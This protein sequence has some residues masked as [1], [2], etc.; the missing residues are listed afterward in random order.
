MWGR[1]TPTVIKHKMALVTTHNNVLHSNK[2]CITIHL[3]TSWTQGPLSPSSGGGMLV[4][5]FPALLWESAPAAAAPHALKTSV[6]LHWPQP[7]PVWWHHCQVV[8]VHTQ[9]RPAH[10]HSRR[11]VTVKATD[12]QSHRHRRLSAEVVVLRR[13]AHTGLFLKCYET[14]K[15]FMGHMGGADIV[16][17][18]YLHCFTVAF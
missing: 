4:S 2:N 1:H 3:S 11:D 8:H 10:T 12:T 17:E 9:L 18:A 14:L 13:E 7:H 6:P 5:T 16:L 15:Q